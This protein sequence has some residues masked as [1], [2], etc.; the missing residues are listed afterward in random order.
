MGVDLA[1]RFSDEAARLARSRRDSLLQT[2]K[3]PDGFV[4]RDRPSRKN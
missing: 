3:G 2:T 1:G 4:G